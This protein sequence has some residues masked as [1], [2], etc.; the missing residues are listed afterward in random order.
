VYGLAFDLESDYVIVEKT[1]TYS[2]VYFLI[3]NPTILS[4]SVY[5]LLFA[6]IIFIAIFFVCTTTQTKHC[7]KNAIFE[8]IFGVFV[9]IGVVFAIWGDG[10]SGSESTSDY[11]PD[12]SIHDR[13]M[14]EI[15]AEKELRQ[16][17]EN[18]FRLVTQELKSKVPDKEADK[19]DFVEHKKKVL[20]DLKN[21]YITKVQEI[22]RQKQNLPVTEFENRIQVVDQLEEIITKKEQEIDILTNVVLHR[23]PDSIKNLEEKIR[24]KKTVESITNILDEK[25][26][27]TVAKAIRLT[28][29][30]SSKMKEAESKHYGFFTSYNNVLQQAKELEPDMTDIELRKATIESFYINAKLDPKSSEAKELASLVKKVHTIADNESLEFKATA[31]YLLNFSNAKVDNDKKK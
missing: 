17:Y 4:F 24:T 21:D 5:G 22:Q 3:N 20:L 23:I 15:E 9:I 1:I 31:D 28:E 6:I 29:E 2:F 26:K 14:A 8:A 10:D 12:T 13:F 25:K 18:K 7:Q 19:E 16:E 30:L 27:E 11:V